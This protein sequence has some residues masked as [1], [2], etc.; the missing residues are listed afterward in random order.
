MN[1]P[2]G[3]SIAIPE[4]YNRKPSYPSYG[5]RVADKV[6]IAYRNW[7]PTMS[8][9]PECDGLIAV[10]RVERFP[11]L[12]DFLGAAR[13]AL[14]I[15][16]GAADTVPGTGW[17]ANEQKYPMEERGGP[18]GPEIVQLLAVHRVGF[19]DVYDDPALMY[20]AG[21]RN[22]VHVGVWITNR[23][24]GARRAVQLVD[25]IADSFET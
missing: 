8:G 5:E 16:W 7:R 4:P 14:S 1:L 19:F 10:G 17:T 23:Q 12:R 24:G 21:F 9:H 2:G 15:Q 25:R 6:L 13:A 3:G 22:G 20:V 11:D 18:N